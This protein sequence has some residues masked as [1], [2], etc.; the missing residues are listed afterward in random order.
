MPDPPWPG[1]PDTNMQTDPQQRPLYSQQLKIRIQKSE[2]LNR[3]VL[4]INLE[5]EKSAEAIEDEVIAKLLERVGINKVL[6]EGLQL[7]P[8]RFPRKVYVWFKEGVDLNQFCKDECYKLGSG[9]KTGLIKP[10]DRKE[11]EVIIKGLNLNTP[12]SMAMEYLGLFGKVVKNVAVYVTNKEGPFAGLKN[13][14]RKYMMDFSGG[15][16]LGTYHLIDGANVHVSYPGQRRT[17]ARCHG[18]PTSCPGGGLAKR[19]DENG[20]IKVGLRD[21][22]QALWDEIGFKPAEFTLE[23]ENGDADED[24]EIREKEGFTP[25][26][27]S[28][29]QMSEADKLNLNG[30]SVRNLPLDI[31]EE[32][33]QT[34]LVS[35]GLP[36]AHEDMK[37]TR[38]KF[39]TTIDAEGLS[40]EICST[41]MANIEETDA[42]DRKIYCKGIIAPLEDI[43]LEEERTEEKKDED[44]TGD[45]E[46]REVTGEN[47]PSQQAK[48]PPN[49]SPCKPELSQ[50][51]PGLFISKNQEK[52]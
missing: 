6:V 1:P 48:T 23:N 7:V 47:Q 30:V 26:H 40:A 45:P 14:D 42:F 8:K 49:K 13:G 51:K 5:K 10:M 3:N 37:I 21:H 15:R 9:V 33:A 17:C 31:A 35:V 2:R 32:Q 34:F 24:V 29:P 39:S 22:M 19:C 12:D 18:T 20:G 16:N 28:R 52:S 50:P 46:N 4:E 36:E 38:L 25:L 43:N 41:I 11:V 44:E 27:K